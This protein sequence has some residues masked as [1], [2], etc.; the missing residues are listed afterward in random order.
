M[1]IEMSTEID[2]PSERVWEVMSDVERW[3]EWTPSITSIERLDEAPFGAG[4]RAGASRRPSQ[5]GTLPGKTTAR[6]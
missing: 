3:H 1:K 5:D 4:S 2:A 6:A